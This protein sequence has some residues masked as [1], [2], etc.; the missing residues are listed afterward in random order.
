MGERDTPVKIN[1][2]AIKR[3]IHSAIGTPRRRDIFRVI[4]KVK[5]YL[6]QVQRKINTTYKK[7][8]YHLQSLKTKQSLQNHGQNMNTG[9]QACL[10]P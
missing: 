4:V 3:D 1:V 6:E 7:G 2:G 9:S 5:F 10:E 8:R